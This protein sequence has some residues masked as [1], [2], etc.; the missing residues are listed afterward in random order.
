MAVR[1]LHSLTHKDNFPI[2]SAQ[3]NGFISP[4]SIIQERIMKTDVDDFKTSLDRLIEI[5]IALSTE[6][7]IDILLEKIVHHARELTHADAGTLYLFHD[8]ELHFEIMQNSSMGLFE[9]GKGR[10]IDLPPVALDKSNVSAYAAITRKTVNIDDV[11]KSD[12][13]DFTGPRKYDARTGRF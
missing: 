11:Y 4:T 7:D 1:F 9:G 3:K 8:D 2:V 10:H 13:F 5:G 6:L 12:E